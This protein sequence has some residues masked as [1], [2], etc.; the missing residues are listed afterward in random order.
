MPVSH[1]HSVIISRVGDGP[2]QD[3]NGTNIRNAN[4]NALRW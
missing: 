3:M 4:G 2:D 1:C